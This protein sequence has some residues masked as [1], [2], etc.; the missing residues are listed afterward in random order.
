MKS[1]K[2]IN[3]LVGTYR[4]ENDE[5]ID[6]TRLYNLPLPK[7]GDSSWY[8]RF[9]YI[10]LYC[11]GAKPKAFKAIFSTVLDK[12]SLARTGYHFSA[13]Q[14]GGAYVMFDLG[15]RV[16][17]EATLT[18]PR[19]NVYVCSSRWHGVIDSDFFDRPY[20][21]CGGKSMPYIFDHLRPFW[22]KWHSAKVFNPIQTDFMKTL[23]VQVDN[24]VPFPG[25]KNPKFTFIDLFAGIGGVRMGFQDA[26]NEC[27]FSSEW[28]EQAQS[29][30]KRNYGGDVAGDITKIDPKTIGEFDILCGGFPCQPFSTIGKRQG[31]EHPTQ[32]TLFFY[33][34]EILREC[35]PK[36]FFLENVLGIMSHDHGNTYKVIMETLCDELGYETWSGVLDASDFGVPQRRKR[37]Y[38]V[39]YKKSLGIRFT[40]PSGA[41]KNKPVGIGKF[42]EKNVEGYD[43]TKHL[44]G[45][46]IFK[47]NDGRPEI[48]DEHSDFPVKTLC[49]SY[50]KIQRLTGTFVRGGKTGLRLLTANECKAIQGFPREFV[51]PVSRTSMHH[52]F[53]NSVAVPVIREIA[54]VMTKQL[55]K[56]EE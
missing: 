10:V 36:A 16:S 14:H 21:D 15:E 29:T 23:G 54:K 56:K 40:P 4:L 55:S 43:I 25:P 51:V 11:E 32:G 46:Y 19:A 33:I 22:R 50:H 39:G 17:V 37:L 1:A 31:F 5:W 7:E 45:S 2:E 53:G 30:Y 18:N 34:K 26:G 3:V 20:P 47:K 52:Q 9:S 44:Q 12:R 8:T 41:F 28:D 24:T 49:A 42:L 48:V 13:T 6:R 38:F 35:N 27:I